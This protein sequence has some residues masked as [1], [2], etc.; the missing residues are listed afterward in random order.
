MAGENQIYERVTEMA[1]K[2]PE[3]NDNQNK[4]AWGASLESLTLI[5]QLGL[6]IAIPIVLGAMAGRWLD[7]KLETGNVFSILLLLFGIGGGIAGAY[8][9]VARVIKWKK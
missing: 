3:R 4:T 8:Q 6:T 5:T 9:L 1:K 2:D 7:G